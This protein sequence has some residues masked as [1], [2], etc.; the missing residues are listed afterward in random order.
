M[1]APEEDLAEA[2]PRDDY[3]DPAER[4][5]EAPPEDAFEQ[6]MPADPRTEP[7]DV[8]RGL[9]VSGAEVNEYDA[10][11]QARVVEGDEDYR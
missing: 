4:D 11:E 3:L 9:E 8:H 2:A 6:S 7:G 10:V 5:P 1:T